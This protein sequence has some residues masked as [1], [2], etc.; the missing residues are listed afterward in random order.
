MPSPLN[1]LV[2]RYPKMLTEQIPSMPSRHCSEYQIWLR[3]AFSPS[4]SH[5]DPSCQ[6]SGPVNKSID[7]SAKSG[8]E[9][10]ERG[11]IVCRQA[12]ALEESDDALIGIVDVRPVGLVPVPIRGEVPVYDFLGRLEIGRA[13]VEVG[14][15]QAD[16]RSLV[17]GS[18]EVVRHCPQRLTGVGPLSRPDQCHVGIDARQGHVG[19]AVDEV[20]DYEDRIER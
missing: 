9:R 19:T 1:R 11:G 2:I 3:V 8:N 12:V 4:P 5:C 18:D 16:V 15:A 10:V 6:L 13:P 20:I 14:N 17:A 7:P